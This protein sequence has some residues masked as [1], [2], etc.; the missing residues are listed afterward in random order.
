MTS[1]QAATAAWV[2]HYA[3]GVGA[4]D[5][6]KVQQIINISLGSVEN[7][8]AKRL[9]QLLENVAEPGG[10]AAHCCAPYHLPSLQML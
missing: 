4:Q 5:E 3:Y 9:K 1:K 2:Q 7:A 10:C 6:Q 8:G